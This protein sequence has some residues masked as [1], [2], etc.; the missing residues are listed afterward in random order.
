[1]TTFLEEAGFVAWPLL[2]LVAVSLWHS[3]RYLA[4]ARTRHLAAAS[5][6]ALLSLVL[7]ALSLVGG[8]Q[9]SVSAAMRAGSGT[10]LVLLGLSESLNGVVLAL[11]TCLLVTLLLSI[12]T[13]RSQRGPARAAR[14]ATDGSPSRPGRRP[15]G[16]VMSRGLH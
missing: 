2:L 8:F 13:Y 7:A 3:V 15:A 16:V 10:S 9:Y 5:G 6:A 12:G 11:L 4:N 14:S 1:M